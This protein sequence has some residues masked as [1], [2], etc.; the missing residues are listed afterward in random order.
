VWSENQSVQA[1][2]KQ[3]NRHAGLL[4]SSKAAM[5]VDIE[6]T[7]NF[8]TEQFREKLADLVTELFAAGVPVDVRWGFKEI[9][10]SEKDIIF[11]REL[12]PLAQF[13]FIVRDPID[14][15]ASAIAAFSKEKTLW[16]AA[17]QS[18]DVVGTMET[19]LE[20]YSNRAL[21][22]AKG[23]VNCIE[24]ND[25]YLIKYED[26]R[27]KPIDSVQGIC[28]CL[29]CSS[30]DP[31]QIKLI[32]GDVRRATDTRAVKQRIQQEFLGEKGVQEL[33]TVYKSLGY[34]P[35]SS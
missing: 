16:E 20:K 4:L 9:R 22:V 18:D 34:S 1:L 13:I 19:Q 33:L 31:E 15:L 25:G 29:R 12:F 6:W 7:N 2:L 11:L 5:G 8:S 3:G 26:L 17:E 21:S 27:D 28:Q 10:Y 32:A 35:S 23:I 14:T 24:K 30:P